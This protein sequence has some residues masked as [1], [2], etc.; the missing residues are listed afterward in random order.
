MSS[1]TSP[2]APVLLIKSGGVAALAEWRASFDEF[3]PGLGLDVRAWD[4]PEVDPARVQFVL[5]WQ[6][7][8]GRLAQ[9]PN[10]KAIISA[11]A[12]V[13]HILA[14]PHLPELP[15]VR[16][17]TPETQ[18]RMAEFTLMSSLMLLK[19]MPRIIAQ[20]VRAEWREFSTPR[21]A[22][23]TRVGVLGLGA[24]GLSAARMH[25][26]VGFE[27]AGWARSLR[28]EKGLACFAGPDTLPDF[29]AR[30]DILICLLPET[31]DTRHLID[32]DLL[33]QLPRGAAVI[34][35]GRG[36]HVCLPDL[37]AALDSGHV[38]GAVLD[39]FDEEPLPDEAA[40]WRHPR[41]L[42]TP[43]AAATPSRRERA[44]Q[45][46]VAIAAMLGGLPPPHLY[47]RSKGY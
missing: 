9:F 22:R 45:A 1:P 24:L 31:T 39:V 21:T 7:E 33:R 41:V 32:A 25:A 26:A 14:D 15:I 4:D 11:A 40:V 17:V 46:A 18:Q 2:L 35:V 23:E 44:R 38:S 30:T 37:L 27:T 8:P 6:P 13:D 42:V 36:S 47:D 3:A 43:H 28:S 20:Q 12:G 34:N 19:D 10:L 29:L 5:V 16:M